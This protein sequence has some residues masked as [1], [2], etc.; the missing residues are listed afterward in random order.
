MGH[1]AIVDEEATY[2]CLTLDIN[3]KP[4][5]NKLFPIQFIEIVGFVILYSDKVA[6]CQQIQLLNSPDPLWTA[7]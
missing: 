6:V 5:I 1:F 3:P 4:L 7:P 2:S